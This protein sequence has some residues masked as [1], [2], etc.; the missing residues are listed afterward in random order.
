MTERAKPNGIGRLREH[1]LH[2]ALCEWCAQPGDAFEVDVEGYRI[3]VVR[4]EQFIEVQTGNFSGLRGKLARLLP[5]H[6]VTVVYPVALVRWIVRLP[7]EAGAPVTRRRSPRKGRATDLFDELVRIAPLAAHPHLRLQVVYT[8]EEELRRDD[9]RGSWRR[10]GVSIVDRR[11]LEVVDTRSFAT[12][13]D[14]A[15]LLPQDAGE[16]TSRDLARALAIRLPQARRMAYCLHALGA[17][18]QA[19]KRGRERLWL[20]AAP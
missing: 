7:V 10:K 5:E 17:L 1:A 15:A 19:G 13:D 2:A 18:E 3:D 4:G 20:R 11:L 9:G 6:P 14:Y 12:V 8:H 16:F